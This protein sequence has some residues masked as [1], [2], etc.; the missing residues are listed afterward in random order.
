MGN[1]RRSTATTTWLA[2]TALA[3]VSS[4]A[5]CGSDDPQPTSVPSTAIATLEATHTATVAP[6][7]TPVPSATTEPTS[8]PEALEPTRTRVSA[9]FLVPSSESDPMVISGSTWVDARGTP[10]EV[11]AFINGQE[12]GRAKSGF[13]NSEPPS[14]LPFLLLFVASDVQQQGC[15][16]LGAEVTFTINGRPAN[17]TIEWQPGLQPFTLIAGPLFAQYYGK[18]RLNHGLPPRMRVYAFIDDVL[19]G[20]QISGGELYTD[21]E[22]SYVVLVDPEELRPGCGRDGAEIELVLT[23]EGGSDIDL[24]TEV[25]H[26][27]GSIERTTVDFTGQIPTRS[28]PP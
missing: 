11:I 18:F 27:G 14:P 21:G 20:E 3:L 22:W 28:L 23:V 13:L 4:A 10:G 19:C 12:C 1:R 24:G 6:S 7:E 5:I 8:T 2:I 25:W 9:D 15:G 16:V 26:P 17:N